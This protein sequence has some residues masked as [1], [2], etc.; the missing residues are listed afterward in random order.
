MGSCSKQTPIHCEQWEHGLMVT[1][2]AG[3][4]SGSVEAYFRHV[5]R[6]Q[7]FTALSLGVPRAAPPNY[8]LRVDNWYLESGARRLIAAARYQIARAFV[9]RF[10]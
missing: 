4:F 3:Y 8:V 2:R 10:L 5:W 7:S 6:A 9:G 1:I